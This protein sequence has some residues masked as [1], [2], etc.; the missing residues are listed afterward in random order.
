MAC[1][2]EDCRDFNVK[3]QSSGRGMPRALAKGSCAKDWEVASP[4]PSGEGNRGVLGTSKSHRFIKVGR[5]IWRS[6][7][8]TPPH[9]QWY[10]G[11]GSLYVW[12]R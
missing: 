9:P 1:A 7:S 8:P 5:D 2:P 3:L 4:T 6:S 12:K 11:I 10:S